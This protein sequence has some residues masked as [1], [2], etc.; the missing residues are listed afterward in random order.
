[1]SFSTVHL[2]QLQLALQAHRGAYRSPP[3]KYCYPH[4]DNFGL[5]YDGIDGHRQ[6]VSG[7]S[8]DFKKWLIAC[9]RR[10]IGGGTDILGFRYDHQPYAS[11]TSREQAGNHYFYLN[12][13]RGKKRYVRYVCVTSR[14]ELVC[15]QMIL[16]TIFYD[17]KYSEARDFH[18][19]ASAP[20]VIQGAQTK[21]VNHFTSGGLS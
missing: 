6:F 8:P 9:L 19:S 4:V 1:M 11:I 15:P 7:D 13:K 17:C 10:C 12:Y 3:A 14:P 20:A 2:D 5:Y 21:L 18:R 16:N